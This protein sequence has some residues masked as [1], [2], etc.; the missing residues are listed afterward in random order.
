MR[1]VWKKTT[2]VA[3]GKRGKQT[4]AWYCKDPADVENAVE[5]KKNIGEDCIDA[6]TKANT[7]Y[8]EKVLAAVNKLRK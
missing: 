3:F 4:V 8:N 2:K 1:M 5:S 6:K 7:C